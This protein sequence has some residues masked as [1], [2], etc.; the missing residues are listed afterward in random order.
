[1][2]FQSV[3]SRCVSAQAPLLLELDFKEIFIVC[4]LT[5]DEDVK[6][7]GSDWKTG[8]MAVLLFGGQDDGFLF[9]RLPRHRYL[10]TDAHV[11]GTATAGWRCCCWC[12]HTNWFW[13][14]LT[15][16]AGGLEGMIWETCLICTKT[17]VHVVFHPRRQFSIAVNGLSVPRCAEVRP[18]WT[19]SRVG[20]KPAREPGA[21][22]SPNR[23]Q[24]VP[25]SSTRLVSP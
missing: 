24:L 10:P 3:V 23:S 15:W 11:V 20:L 25:T 4:N 7:R 21:V 9:L 16:H 19:V 5:R 14:Q 6:P 22:A 17:D 13:S 1:M 2:Q 18:K 12:R 8:C